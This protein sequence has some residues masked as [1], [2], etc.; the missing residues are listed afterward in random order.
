MAEEEPLTQ[1]NFPGMSLADW[2]PT[3]DTIHKY[4]QVLGE[5]RGTLTPRSKHW[6]HINLRPDVTGLSTPPI[7]GPGAPGAFAFKM[8]LN[9]VDHK[10][11]VA[12]SAG[13]Q[14]EIGLRGQSL[15]SFCDQT[16]SALADLGIR[17]EIDCRHFED[18]SPRV[19]DRT[20]VTR[21]W[22]VL[23]Q[24][25]TIF[26]EFKSTL[27]QE[28]SAVN[29]WPHHFDLAFTWFSGRR[30]P[31]VDPA[32]EEYADEQMSFGFTTGDEGIPDPYFYISA[33][34]MPDSLCRTTLPQEVTWYSEDWQ[35]AL[36]M[37]EVLT[38]T[39]KP[40]E[41]LLTYLRTMQRAGAGLMK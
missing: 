11:V 29:F 22:Q 19:Y 23:G 34:P 30:V 39:D 1:F 21:F 32:D 40:K 13:R 5:I 41:K 8:Q 27:R 36:M 9:L 31:G 17:P 2:Q 14:L 15:A 10:L 3:R 24:V 16:L 7:P 4:S 33:Y 37:Y 25:A 18:N 12:S 26:E 35:G 20:A 38:L 28:T 6:W